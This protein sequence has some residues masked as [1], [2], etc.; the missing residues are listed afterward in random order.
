MRMILR[1]SRIRLMMRPTKDPTLMME[2]KM[3]PKNIRAATIIQTK[4][5]IPLQYH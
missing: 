4:I 5:H 1:G 3:K 2:K